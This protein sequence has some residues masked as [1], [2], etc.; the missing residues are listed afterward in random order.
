MLFRSKLIR[1]GRPK[2]VITKET[3]KDIYGIDASLEFS[4]NGEYPICTE[5]ELLREE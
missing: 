4:E 5:Y 1:Q 3:L 2:D